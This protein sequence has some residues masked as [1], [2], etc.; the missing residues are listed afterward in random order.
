VTVRNEGEYLAKA[1]HVELVDPSDATVGSA[2]ADRGLFQ[3]ESVLV[4]VMTPPHDRYTGPYMIYLEWADG[5]GANRVAS[6]V[7]VGRP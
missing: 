5:R 6:G 4:K 3:G 2:M 1:I 7:E